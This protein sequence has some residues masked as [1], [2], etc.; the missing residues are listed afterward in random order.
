[1]NIFSICAKMHIQQKKYDGLGKVGCLFL[2]NST[3]S[4]Q[5]DCGLVSGLLPIDIKL[6][7]EQLESP[8]SKQKNS[9]KAGKKSTEKDPTV[10]SK[11]HSE[12]NDLKKK[13]KNVESQKKSTSELLIKP[14]DKK[15]L[16]EKR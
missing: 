4:F 3:I 5:C 6:L 11:I 16:P 9:G 15:N 13:K 7:Q 1:M 10:E 14:T 12:K 8:K 2:F